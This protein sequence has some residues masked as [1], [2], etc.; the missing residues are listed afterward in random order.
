MY[1]FIQDVGALVCR[2]SAQQLE[3]TYKNQG[4]ENENKDYNGLTF[5]TLNKIIDDVFE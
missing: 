1:R 4:T 3:S 5:D 2:E